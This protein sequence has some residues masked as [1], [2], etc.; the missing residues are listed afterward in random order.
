MLYHDFLKIKFSEFINSEFLNKKIHMKIDSSS[1]VIEI[2]NNK[3][4]GDVSTNIAM[5]FVKKLKTTPKLLAEKLCKNLDNFSQIEKT[6]IVGPG[7]LNIFFTKAFW[8]QQLRELI[9]NIGNY[10]YK[11][12][13]K[14]VCLEYVSANPTGLMHIGHARGAVLGDTIASILEEVGHDVCREY[15]INDAG[16]QIKKLLQTV[17]FH[18]KAKSDKTVSISDELYPGDYLRELSLIIAKT[19]KT[20]SKNLKINLDSILALIMKDIKNDLSSI[21]VKHN[22]FISEKEISTK[23]NVNDLIKK[24]NEKELSYLGYQDKPMS[25]LDKNW[26]KEQQLLFRSKKLGDDSDRALLKPNGE[27]TYF[28]SDILYHQEKVERNFDILLNIWGID[29]SGYVKRLKNSINALNPKKEINFIIKLTALVNLLEGKKT[30]KMS[31][32]K[33]NY[34]TLREVV[35]KV[36]SDVLRF[37]M[38]SRNADKKID[39]DFETVKLKTKDNPVFYVQYAYARCKS[40]I[41]TFNKTFDRK[42]NLV[43][44]I[45]TNLVN[46]NNETE[47]SLVIKLCNFFNI[48]LS[49]AKFYEPHR[50]TNYLYELAKDLHVYW[51]LGKINVNNKIIIEKDF[52]LS[53]SRITL[54]F[55]VSLIIKKGMDILKINCPENM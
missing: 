1:V 5:I 42:L 8:Q 45:N 18:I 11:V 37:M 23:E 44:L 3:K 28:M 22:S 24:L 33:G 32:R 26:K 20:I 54:V 34:I 9:S 39:F 21:G 43:D 12:K 10:N 55:A 17:I 40:L 53:L 16:E 14:R 49:S 27:L 38:I 46:L 50:L 25:S 31:K 36:G 4:Y 13:K 41:E 30:V 15:Y 52:N 6:E 51:G 47:I 19:Q 2:P 35:E 48:I 29:H 7:F